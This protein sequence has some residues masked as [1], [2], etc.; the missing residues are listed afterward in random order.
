MEKKKSQFK[1]KLIL[2]F[3]F[4]KILLIIFNYFNNIN[5]IIKSYFLN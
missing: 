4:L 1:K 2:I 3:I 5:Y